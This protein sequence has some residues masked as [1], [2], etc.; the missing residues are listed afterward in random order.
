MC[1]CTPTDDE[2]RDHRDAAIWIGHS[3]TL[4]LAALKK[5]RITSGSAFIAAK[6]FRST[7]GPERLNRLIAVTGA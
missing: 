4:D 7:C 1:S 6:E 2:L 5:S 3:H